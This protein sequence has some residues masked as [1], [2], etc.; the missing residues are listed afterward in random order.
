MYDKP[1]SLVLVCLPWQAPPLSRWK[2]QI[3]SLYYENSFVNVKKK[4]KKRQ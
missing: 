4:K 3:L 1:L 2:N